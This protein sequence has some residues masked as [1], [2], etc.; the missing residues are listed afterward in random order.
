MTDEHR[1][2]REESPTVNQLY[3]PQEDPSNTGVEYGIRRE[4]VTD[5]LFPRVFGRGK[6]FHTGRDI[7]ENVKVHEGHWPDS[8]IR[9]SVR[10]RDESKEG[11]GWTEGVGRGGLE[12]VVS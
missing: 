3:S 7:A 6:E 1:C 8:E 9:D 2:R 4:P 12:K 5:W 11:D 10:G